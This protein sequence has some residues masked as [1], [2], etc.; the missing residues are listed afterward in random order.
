MA[1][2][3][4]KVRQAADQKP[5]FPGRIPI[6]ESWIRLS[7][8]KVR[9]EKHF[10]LQNLVLNHGGAPQPESAS[11]NLLWE[12]SMGQAFRQGALYP[13]RS[14]KS[15]KPRR[16]IKSAEFPR[17]NR[18]PLLLKRSVPTFRRKR[19]KSR[20]HRLRKRYTITVQPSRWIH[21]EIRRTS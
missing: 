1:R 20:R 3:E 17:Q 9:S 10:F 18:K 12:I 15:Q 8:M 6:Q 5:A 4:R 2:M 11:P 7:G 13:P 19:R 16:L 21:T 14:R